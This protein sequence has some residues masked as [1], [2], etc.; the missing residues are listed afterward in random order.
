LVSGVNTP[1]QAVLIL[2]REK[3][4]EAANVNYTIAKFQ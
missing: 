2:L 3:I 4:F 1:G